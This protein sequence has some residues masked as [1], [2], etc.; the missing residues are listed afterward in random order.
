[1]GRT[2]GLGKA[3]RV[4]SPQNLRT[5][6]RVVLRD[7]L[8]L[9]AVFGSAAS[10]LLF[11]RRRVRR[12]QYEVLDPRA[13]TCL[14]RACELLWLQG[15]AR[16][17]L[18]PA[19]A[20]LAQQLLQDA[21]TFFQDTAATRGAHVPPMERSAVDS[22]SGYVAER[23]REFLELHLRAGST[24]ASPESKVALMCSASAFAA[25]AHVLC[26]RVLDELARS[27]APLASVISDERAAA[28]G[29]ADSDGACA[30][31]AAAAAGGGPSSA[32]CGAASFSASMLR[33][34]SYSCESDYPPH[35][36]LGLLTLAPRSSLAGLM[37]QALHPLITPHTCTS[38]H[39]VALA[40]GRGPR[41]GLPQLA[42]SPQPRPSLA[43]GPPRRCRRRASGWPW[44]RVWLG[45]RRSSLAARRSRRL[46]DRPHYRTR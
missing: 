37:V 3:L 27:S 34:H 44:R 30:T 43:G 12:R 23:G 31:V 46:V 16:L 22:R 29:P 15:F 25:A 45:T 8:V 18:G 14:R 41:A 19:D 28:Q 10:L 33:V 7:P 39:A 2:L 9:T 40:P 17:R 42:P 11:A 4:I 1:V 13:S 6:K 35:E 36:D 21:G 20:R 26:E 5:K 38:S 32:R 24:H